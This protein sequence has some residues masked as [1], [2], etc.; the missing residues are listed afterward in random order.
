[1]IFGRF[2]IKTYNFVPFPDR[3]LGVLG[4]FNIKNRDFKIKNAKFYPKMSWK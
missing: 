4:Q 1:M 2:G 3:K